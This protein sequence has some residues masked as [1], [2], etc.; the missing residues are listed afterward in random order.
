MQAYDDDDRRVRKAGVDAL[1][2]LYE[3]VGDLLWMYVSGIGDAKVHQPLYTSSLHF[4]LV[5]V[6]LFY[7]GK[8]AIVHKKESQ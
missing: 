8:R 1:V 2:R 5:S 3:R 6:Y 7:Y 4:D